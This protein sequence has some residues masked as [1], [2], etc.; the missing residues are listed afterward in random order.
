MLTLSCQPDAHVLKLRDFSDRNRSFGT[1]AFPNASLSA[2]RAGSVSP[3]QSLGYGVGMFIGPERQRREGLFR[4]DFDVPAMARC[5]D[6]CLILVAAGLQPARGL[7]PLKTSRGESSRRDAIHH[8]VNGCGP[9]PWYHHGLRE[10]S[11][12]DRKT[13]RF[14][15]SR[16]RETSGSRKSPRQKSHDFRYEFRRNTRKIRQCRNPSR[17]CLKGPFTCLR[18]GFAMVDV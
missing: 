3:R 2:C 14:G 16:S 17:R 10:R 15:R 5:I 7:L 1:L 13:R 9:L 6:S 18:C 12:Q 4:L 11:F 8:D